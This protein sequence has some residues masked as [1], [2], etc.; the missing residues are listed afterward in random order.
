MHQ[1]L[2]VLIVKKAIC[3]FPFLSRV[4]AA[5][6]KL[7]VSLIYGRVTS[8]PGSSLLETFRQQN[9]FFIPWIR[10]SEH[11]QASRPIDRRY[12][13]SVRGWL[14]DGLGWS[15]ERQSCYWESYFCRPGTKH[16][17]Y[18]RNSHVHC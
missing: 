12:I 16:C 9:P 5:E 11:D 18:R 7:S 8:L 14:P 6:K 4:R 1:E 13:S 10:D 15:I 17:H 2:V 3:V